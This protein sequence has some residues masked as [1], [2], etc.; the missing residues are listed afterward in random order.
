MIYD[1]PMRYIPNP[2]VACIPRKQPSVGLILRHP[3][4]FILLANRNVDEGKRTQRYALGFAR[5]SRSR[6]GH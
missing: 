2:V 6:R 3:R 5:P 4:L 1:I